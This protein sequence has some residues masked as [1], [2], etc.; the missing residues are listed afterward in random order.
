MM[1]RYK[2]TVSSVMRDYVID[3]ESEYEAQEEGKRLFDEEIDHNGGKPNFSFS[4]SIYVGAREIWICE[5]CGEDFGRPKYMTIRTQKD[6]KLR[7]LC[8]V[9]A[10]EEDKAA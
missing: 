5:R 1:R 10:E 9:C 4:N 7:F 2:V 8:F 6:G 3:A